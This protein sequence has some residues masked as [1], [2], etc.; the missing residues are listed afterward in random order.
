M[1]R[2]RMNRKYKT[3][4]V[5]KWA[6]LICSIISAIL[7]AVLVAIKVAPSFPHVSVGVGV[8]SVGAFVL[9]LGLIFIIRGLEKRYGK[10]LPWATTT[11]L[12]SWV[13]WGMIFATQKV[14]AQAAQIS[15]ALAI[16]ASVAFVLSLVSDL[17]KVL[18]KTIK[19]EYDRMN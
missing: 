5:I 16:G 4:K 6:S 8:A 10:H 12:W 17:F 7:P 19:E 3:Y 15:L 2:T 11:V 1:E 18:E 13:L 14:I 9:A